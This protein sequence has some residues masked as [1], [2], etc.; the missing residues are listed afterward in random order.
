MVEVLDAVLRVV[1]KGGVDAVRYR[2]VADEAGVSLGTVSYHYTSREA[3]L[4]A[5]LTHYL[6]DNVRALFALRD[7]Y[8]AK[9]VEDVA[10]YVVELIRRDFADKRRRVLAEYELMVFAARDPE[11][12]GALARYEGAMVAEM[13][14]ALERL[15]LRAPFAAARTLAEIIRGFELTG[16]GAPARD[17]EDLRGRVRTVLDAYSGDSKSVRKGGSHVTRSPR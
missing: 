9:S 4:R 14:R 7:E 8:S 5:A 10:D 17:L 2:A 13:A 15:G 16:L 3:L 11:V 6:E 12:A 1:V